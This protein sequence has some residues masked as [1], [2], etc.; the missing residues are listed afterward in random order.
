MDDRDPCPPAEVLAGFCDGVSGPAAYARIEE[1]LSG[2]PDC[3]QA[4][5]FGSRVLPEVPIVA[6]RARSW[7]GVAAAAAAVLV[8]CG[9][10]AAAGV[11]RAGRVRPVRHGTLVLADGTRRGFATEAAIDADAGTRLEF[12]DGTS[13]RA[14]HGAV[15]RLREPLLG[16][17][18]RLRLDRGA[19]ELSVAHEAGTVLVES[20]LG[21]ARVT[22]TRFSVSLWP[23]PRT[24]GGGGVLLEVAVS[25][26][27]VEVS[28]GSAGRSL[29]LKPGERAYLLPG[30][31]VIGEVDAPP[32]PRVARELLSQVDPLLGSS[33]PPG[34]ALALV[35]ARLRRQ[36]RL[37]VD[38]IA[39]R[40]GDEATPPERRRMWER[41]LS[42]LGAL[43]E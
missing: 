1:H 26:G 10:L 21:I 3:L 16:E 2:C 39:E 38:G 5:S 34:P 17:R 32:D 12:A 40:I 22:G 30:G 18:L 24:P 42:S 19:V 35:A 13:A 28:P 25:E 7:R 43:D 11:L 36:G 4:V 27:G 15:L 20:P 23:D 8:V 29:L 6:G 33:D 37:A 41:F 31:G 9:A 14:T